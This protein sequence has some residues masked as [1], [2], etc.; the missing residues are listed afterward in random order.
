MHTH[1]HLY[2]HAYKHTHDASTRLDAQDIRQNT[3][4]LRPRFSRIGSG[5]PPSF[6]SPAIAPQ[7]VVK[8]AQKPTLLAKLWEKLHPGL[9]QARNFL[10]THVVGED[11]CF[12]ALLGLIMALLAY[13]IDLAIVMFSYAHTWL[14]EELRS[15]ASLRT[16]WGVGRGVEK[17]VSRVLSL[18][19]FC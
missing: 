5:S 15:V 11:W 12:L 6:P 17:I 14:Y 4:F 19:L 1:G 9:L 7:P 13:L 8:K 10:F 16:K 2:T 3:L 18:L